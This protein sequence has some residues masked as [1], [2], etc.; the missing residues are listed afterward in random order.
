MNISFSYKKGFPVLHIDDRSLMIRTYK[1]LRQSDFSNKE[2]TEAYNSLVARPVKRF[3]D[4]A[5]V[6]ERLSSIVKSEIVPKYRVPANL[7][8]YL[9]PKGDIK[10]IQTCS[11]KSKLGKVIS[12]LYRG[13]TYVEME[14]LLKKKD[15]GSWTLEA[16]RSL[17]YWDISKVKGYGIDTEFW[18]PE[19]AERSGKFR[20]GLASIKIAY[21]NTGKPVAVMSLVLPQGLDQPV[22]RGEKK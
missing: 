16:L 14:E 10:H 15:G 11:M 19:Q 4:K 21:E 7:G 12:A 20:G 1:D 5:Q 6:S 22:L 13:T 17:I 2:L 3:R 18:I 8:T 9:V